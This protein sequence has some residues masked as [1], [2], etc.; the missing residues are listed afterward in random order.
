MTRHFIKFKRAAAVFA[1]AFAI[2]AAVCLRLYAASEQNDAPHI[3]KPRAVEAYALA[4]Q[5]E[6]LDER[7]LS[8]VKNILRLWMEEAVKEFKS[9]DAKK[10]NAAIMTIYYIGTPLRLLDER[11]ETPLSI[12]NDVRMA[13]YSWAEDMA[14]MSGA[15]EKSFFIHP[16]DLKRGFSFGMRELAVW[17][18]KNPLDAEIESQREIAGFLLRALQTNAKLKAEYAEFLSAASLLQEKPNLD[19]LASVDAAKGFKKG[20]L[21]LFAEYDTAQRFLSRVLTSPNVADKTTLSVNDLDAFLLT[22]INP[23][24]SGSLNHLRAVGL[25]ESSIKTAEIELSQ[26]V[27]SA[28]AFM[29][30]FF[31]TLRRE[32]NDKSARLA[33]AAIFFSKAEKEF[34]R[35]SPEEAACEIDFSLQ[36]EL[37]TLGA[38]IKQALL[39]AGASGWSDKTLYPVLSAASALSGECAAFED[40]NLAAAADGQIVA[41][42]ITAFG[43]ETKPEDAIVYYV[44]SSRGGF[45]VKAA[46]LPR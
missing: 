16:S 46:A 42:L 7:V 17:A 21:R 5:R 28:G 19:G 30:H 29:E 25:S 26:Y 9:N 27:K 23:D 45:M 13:A 33:L 15:F 37:L 31:K 38:Q 32:P 39:P 3:S 1:S 20:R 35:K 4:R 11:Y 34:K 44:F 12:D 2:Y 41:K 18:D 8:N 43:K 6:L 40:A 22:A 24:A 36:S 14:G 10:R